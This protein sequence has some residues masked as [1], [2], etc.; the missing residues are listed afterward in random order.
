LKL[1]TISN[2]KNTSPI[3]AA[4]FSLLPHTVCCGIPLLLIAL[5][6]GGLSTASF[7]AQY[8][9]LFTVVGVLALAYGIFVYWRNY[10]KQSCGCHSCGKTSQRC[11][12][13]LLCLAAFIQIGMF[14]F[15][16]RSASAAPTEADIV[17]VTRENKFAFQ[18]SGL[19]CPGCAA[20]MENKIRE[21]EGIQAAE[22]LFAKNLLT[23]GTNSS[24]VIPTML[25]NRFQELGYCQVHHVAQKGGDNP[26]NHH[27]MLSMTDGVSVKETP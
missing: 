6:L 18:L 22:I 23:V 21:M 11:A 16:W 2:S 7:F 26:E 5:G 9:L 8:H 10:R 20:E 12:F 19:H 25:A 27:E 13:C 24:S 14:S 1:A 4:V 3:L 17:A 15:L